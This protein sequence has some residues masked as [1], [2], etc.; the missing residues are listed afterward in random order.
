MTGTSI[1]LNC[2]GC[3]QPFSRRKCDVDKSSRKGY[4][5]SFCD[6]SCMEQY[7][8]RTA[9][10]RDKEHENF[11][12]WAKVNKLGE[13]EN[14]CW[15]WVGSIGKSGYGVFQRGYRKYASHRI[16]WE[17]ANGAIPDEQFVLH[18]CDNRACVRPDHLFLG[19]HWDNMQ[20]MVQKGRNTKGEDCHFAKLTE[21]AIREIRCSMVAFEKSPEELAKKYNVTP[22]L[23]RLIARE[24]TWKH[25]DHLPK[26]FFLMREHDISGISGDG[27][28]ASGA[29]FADGRCVFQWFGKINSVE[30]Y[31]SIRDVDMI[32]G[33]EGKTSIVWID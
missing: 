32:H 30:V 10:Q 9:Q 8:K 3:G 16:S 18:R 5:N 7:A 12:F 24:K 4:K 27:M 28:V 2:S 31:D 29:Q 22:S 14:D 33:H 11:R 15:E 26:R 1:I 13:G 25:V 21:K 19:S 20:D 23:V 17:L 6:R